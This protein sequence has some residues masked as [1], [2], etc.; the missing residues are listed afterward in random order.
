ME[1]GRGREGRERWRKREGGE[2]RGY[3]M[4]RSRKVEDMG[5]KCEEIQ[6]KE[7]ERGKKFS[8]IVA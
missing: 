1:Q 8:A 6:W 7:K 4:K 2:T 5:W 3:K